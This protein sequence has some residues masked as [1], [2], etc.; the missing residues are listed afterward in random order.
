MTGGASG[1]G[2]NYWRLF[3]SGIEIL[4]EACDLPHTGRF[5]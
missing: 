2:T 5:L 3:L 4:G 1:D